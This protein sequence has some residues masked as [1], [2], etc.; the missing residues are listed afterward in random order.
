[1]GSFMVTLNKNNTYDNASPWNSPYINIMC[2]NA[3]KSPH[4]TS[5]FHK[6]KKH[7]ENRY[8]PVF[9]TYVNE[10]VMCSIR[11]FSYYLEATVSFIQTQ[12]KESPLHRSNNFSHPQ[13]YIIDRKP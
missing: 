2:T 1:M 8:L 4:D 12:L 6:R 3:P 5:R 9:Y 13:S 11:E 10:C 7:Y